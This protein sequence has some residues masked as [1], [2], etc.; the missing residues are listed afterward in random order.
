LLKVQDFEILNEISTFTNFNQSDFR[1]VVGIPDSPGFRI[2]PDSGFPRAP[3]QIQI[4]EFKWGKNIRSETTKTKVSFEFFCM[5]GKNEVR[6]RGSNSGFRILPDSG[7]PRA[8]IQIQIQEFKWGKNIR[9]ETTK[10][11]V[12]F[13]FFCMIGKNGTVKWETEARVPDSN[14]GFRIVTKGK[15][16]K[17]S[18]YT[19]QNRKICDVENYVNALQTPAQ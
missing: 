7:F 16:R 3:I 1:D 4:Q 19:I 9:R 2:L 13:E 5:N 10:T 11:K 17:L 15:T 18:F 8:P 6:N 14:S 12:S